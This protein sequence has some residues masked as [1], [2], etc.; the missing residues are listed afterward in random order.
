[1]SPRAIHAMTHGVLEVGPYRAP[2]RDDTYR[3]HDVSPREP[4]N[5]AIVEPAMC[6]GPDDVSP[7]HN[8]MTYGPGAAYDPRC[9]CCWLGTTHTQDKHAQS[10]AAHGRCSDRDC[11]C[12][13]ESEA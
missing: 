7:R 9:A 1:M 13:R 11:R 12:Q 2:W 3:P 8:A 6:A 4:W 5:R 10:L